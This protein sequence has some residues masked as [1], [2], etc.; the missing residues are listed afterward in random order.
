MT[1]PDYQEWLA[2]AVERVAD[3]SFVYTGTTTEDSTAAC[4]VCTF[5]RYLHPYRTHREEYRSE[6][7]YHVVSTTLDRVLELMRNLELQAR[8]HPSTISVNAYSWQD[9]V[10]SVSSPMPSMGQDGPSLW[11]IKAYQDPTVPPGKMIFKNNQG[12]VLAVVDI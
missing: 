12:A 4:G 5:P 10:E 1:D 3:H 9:F 7:A 2:Y 8:A 6:H 11:G